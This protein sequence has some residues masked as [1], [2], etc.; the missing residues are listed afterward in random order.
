MHKRSYREI[1]AF[2][3]MKVRLD[4]NPSDAPCCMKLIAEDGRDVLISMDYELPALASNFGWSLS[5]VQSLTT[6]KG[7]DHD[8]TDGSVDCPGCGVMAN[9]FIEDARAFLYE[10]DGM[11]IDDPGYFD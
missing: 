9:D 2:N 7:C 5:D 10:N 4:S 8:G 1:K 6:F 3:Q 11:E